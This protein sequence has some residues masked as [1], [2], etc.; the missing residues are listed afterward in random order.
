[1]RLSPTK[2]LFQ[3]IAMKICFLKNTLKILFQL[4]PFYQVNG[5]TDDGRL[6]M[7]KAH[8]AIGELKIRY[9]DFILT[10]FFSIH[11]FPSKLYLEKTDMKRVYFF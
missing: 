4:F 11:F 2:E 1:M 9:P 6:P 7:T 8:L 10:Y 5:R 3:M